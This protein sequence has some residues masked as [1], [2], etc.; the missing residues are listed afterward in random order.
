LAAAGYFNITF[1]RKLRRELEMQKYLNAILI[2]FF[3]LINVNISSAAPSWVNN[4]PLW[5][6]YAI[7]NTAL[8]TVE[9]S[10][11]PPGN[12]GP[13]SKIIAWNGA[14]LKRQGSVYLI[15]AAGGHADYAGNEVDAL[16]LNTET[17][18]WV[19][20]HPPSPANQLINQSQFYL[21][22]K[23]SATHTYYA[24]QFIEARNRM[25]IMPSPGMYMSGLPSPTA[26]WPYAGDAGF[27]FSFNL[28]TN[29][30]DAPEY[31]P[32]YSGGGDFTA[33]LVTKH[34]VT[35]DIYYSRSGAGW[36]RWTQATSTW[37]KLSNNGETNYA[38]AAIDPT[39]NRILMVG[40]YGG[41]V[42]PRV[43]DLN[44]NP[45]SVTFGGLGAS[46]LALS[47][48]PGVV[49]DE[50]N[51]KFLVFHNS[52]S[53]IVVR[54]VDAATWFVDTPNITGTLPS[55]RQN[56]IH[57]SVQYVPE[58]GGILLANTYSGNVLFLRT[59]S[60]SSVTTPPPPT[61]TTAPSTP[62][63]LLATALSPSQIN[64]SWNASTD[65]VGVSGYRVYRGGVQIASV[66]STSYQNSGLS[67]STNYSYTVAAFDAA[68][69]ISGQSSPAS[70]ATLTATAPPTSG[71]VIT[72]FILL[73]PTAQSFAPFAVGQP[74]RQGDVEAGSSVVANIPNFQATVKSRWPDG[75]IQFAILAGRVSLQANTPF[76]VDIR[77]GAA[78]SG[79]VLT[80]QDLQTRGANMQ[81]SFQGIGTVELSSLIGSLGGYNT[82]LNQWS[83]GKVLDWV[84]GPEMSSWIYSSPVGND[85]SLT[86][87]FEVRLWKD[88]QME[89]LPWIENG[90]LKKTAIAA[91]T[92][93]VTVS[94]S[95][96]QKFSQSLTIYHHT[97]APL[98]WGTA[99][100]YFMGT[101]PEIT[102]KH[103]MAYF[104]ATKLVPSYGAR[105]ASSSS[106]LGSLTTSYTPFSQANFPPG[107]G[108]TGYH[109]SIGLLPQWDVLYLTSNGDPR[110]LAAITIN[111]YSAGR[112]AIHYRDEKTNR[113]LRFS[114][115]PNLVTDCSGLTSCGASSTNSYTPTPSG[116]N[117]PGWSTSH[118]PSVGYMAY[119]LH[120]RFYFMEQSQFAGTLVFLKQTDTVRQFTKGIL[121][122][123]AGANTTRGV[124]WG[125]RS[126][127]HAALATP[128][129]D[130]LKSEFR[131]VIDENIS[132]YHS[133]YVATSNNPQGVAAPYGD[134]TGA[135]DGMYFHSIWMEDFLTAAFGYILD[136]KAYSSTASTKATALFNWKA[137]SAIGRLGQ[138]GVSTEYDFRDASL[139]T[140]TVAP[141]DTANW[142][143][144]TGPWY[145]SW[146]DLYRATMGA[147]AGTAPS[148]LL[149]GGYFPDPTG[150]WGNFQPAIAYAVTN[151]VSGAST[152]Y[153]RMTSASNWSQ[154]V[155]NWNDVPEWSVI[156]STSL[157]SPPPPTNS[158]PPIPPSNLTLQ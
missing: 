92:G 15:G 89:I 149:R 112:Y 125:L 68:G 27:S 103:D 46:A 79:T 120:G 78:P 145:A 94:I 17:P 127:A 134:Y 33:A 9:P 88:G 69:N 13:S 138:P 97:R 30:W 157:S 40:S 148:N 135:G 87:W 75:S 52:A 34:P 130:P 154:F 70:T 66:A 108:Q 111:A 71:T 115:H 100:S 84:V 133:R 39:R 44:G 3:S 155:T 63:G 55:E 98:V 91:K 142:N 101:A 48:Y 86:A 156:P 49:Y 5:Q 4:L 47:G 53:G 150:Y 61:D 76:R 129:D 11:R 104:Q 36:W 96:V 60:G 131:T 32:R 85:A 147:Q 43:R 123:A 7:P 128:D 67:P 20:L 64:L 122:T 132:Y 54:R 19:Q 105:T 65:N 31:L 151:N 118:G 137:K 119:L 93:I 80:E 12:T 28:S 62:G 144:G 22:L 77:A 72:S 126:Y 24:T 90:Y 158:A 121:E 26:A 82:V 41:G 6:W 110:A 45:I 25:L 10:P 37:V 83:A 153:A 42:G 109:P 18:R 23:P 2:I 106:A 81:V 51:D 73:S 14:T 114:S 59:S 56:G 117:G 29:S 136:T 113:P 146:G 35:E 107:I 21:D 152:A 74:F 99:F 50:A 38:G 141:S 143:A 16:Q 116:G 140:I 1:K 8:S 102:F 58:L 57:N 124:G 95:S 139:Y